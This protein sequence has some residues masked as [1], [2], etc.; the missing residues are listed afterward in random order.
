MS[1]KRNEDLM[2]FLEQIRQLTVKVYL[3]LSVK[4]REN[5]AATRFLSGM[6]D[7]VM[8]QQL[9]ADRVTDTVQS[10]NWT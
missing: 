6:S 3:T 4:D 7:Q 2:D 9:L 10:V 1:Q 5:M 8:V